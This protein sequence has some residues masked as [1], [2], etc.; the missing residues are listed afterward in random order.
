MEGPSPGARMRVGLSALTIAEYFRE[1]LQQ[2]VLLFIDN[3]F[4]FVQA[5]SEVSALLGRLTSAVGYQPTLATEMG[6]FQERITSTRNG[7]ITS[8]QAV[9]VPADDLDATPVLSRSLAAK[10]IYPAVSVLES[11]STM[12]QPGIVGDAHYECA[13][14]VRA[15]LQRYDQLQDIIAILG[16]D[17]LSEEDRLVVNRARKL[18]RFMSQPFFVAGPVTVWISRPPQRWP[19]ALVVMNS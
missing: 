1:D 8:I 9:Y 5:G 16:L 10:G 11:T 14:S 13:Q 7:S 2:D 3:I 6:A 15:Q 19:K 18:E 17:E 12:L 4:R